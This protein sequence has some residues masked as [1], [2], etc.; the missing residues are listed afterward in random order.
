MNTPFV[1]D[2]GIEFVW[3]DDDVP[4]ALGRRPIPPPPATLRSIPAFSCK[5]HVSGALELKL[6]RGEY[7]G[8]PADMAARSSDA[9]STRRQGRYGF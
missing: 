5:P 1:T 7:P 4:T 9:R 3:E 2:D 8:G 6:A